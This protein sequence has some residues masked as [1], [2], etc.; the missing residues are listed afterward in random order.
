[1]HLRLTNVGVLVLLLNACTGLPSKID[2]PSVS[3]A[4][5]RLVDMNLMEQTFAL[6][7]RVQNPNAF[8]IPLHGLNCEVD[9]NGQQVAR[10]VNNQ[11]V[12]LPGLGEQI[13]EVRAITSLNSLL[14]QLT[15]LARSGTP[16]VNYRIKGNLRV[17]NGLV[18]LPFD[19]GGEVGLGSFMGIGKRPTD[20]SKYL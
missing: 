4:D 16:S 12:T 13:V 2:P 20:R 6:K 15:E 8:D 19:Q 17:G 9:L 1:M 3:L 18:P 5:V 11:S 10:G 7:L 14:Q